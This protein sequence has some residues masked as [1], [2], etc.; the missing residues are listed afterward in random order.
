MG[1]RRG[2]KY[3]GPTIGGKFTPILDEMQ[4]SKAYKELNG[5]SA[6]LLHH[7]TRVARNVACKLGSSS[8]HSVDYDFTYSEAKK[9][10]FSE[11]TTRRALHELWEK[12]FISVVKIGGRT[13]SDSRGRLSSRYKLCSFWKTYGHQWH[14]RRKYETSPWETPA[15]PKKNDISRW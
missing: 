12:G 4:L 8:D 15:E 13:A 14:D 3:R 5:N 7:M 1:K 11:S 2:S 9:Y 6:K 10:G